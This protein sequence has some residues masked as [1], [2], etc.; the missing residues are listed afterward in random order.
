MN[1]EYFSR[2]EFIMGEENVFDK[3]DSEFLYKLD[4]LRDRVGFSLVITSSYRSP[5]YNE[6]V[7][8][9]PRSMHLKGRA[10]DVRCRNSSDRAVILYYA[11]QM[12]FTC[13]VNKS[14]I[15]LD[16]RVDQKVFLY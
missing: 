8:G 9:A 12:G 13:G 14:F 1:L 15:H 2:E 16:D 5:E 6:K 3:M 11:L 7:G 4:D 10:V